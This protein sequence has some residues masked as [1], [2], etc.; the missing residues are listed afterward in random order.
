MPNSDSGASPD[1]RHRSSGRHPKGSTGESALADARGEFIDE[2]DGNYAS[3]LEYI[4]TQF[5]EWCTERQQVHTLGEVT[6]LTMRH[7]AQYLNRRVKANRADSSEG[8]SASSARTYYNYVSAFL[9]WA[10][11]TEKLPEN[12]AEKER[13]K[14]PLPEGTTSS[15]DQQ[16]WSPEQ[17]RALVEYVDEQARDAIDEN[18]MD[19][20]EEVRNRALITVL[21][22][23]GVRGSEVLADSRHDR[24]NGLRWRDVDLEETV[25]QVFGKGSQ[26]ME[27]VG[28]TGQTVEPLR[29]LRQ[30]LDPPSESWPVFPSKHPPSLYDRIDASPYD[31]PESDP[32]GYVLEKGI[33]PPSMSVSGARTL[34]KRLSKAA[35]V[36]GLDVE[37]GEYLT[38][39]GARRGVGET[40]FKEV[41]PQRAQRTLRHEDPKTT[42]KMYSHIEASELGEENTGVFDGE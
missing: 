39:H 18:G 30:V 25:M 28:L 1:E 32:W 3:N 12:P 13:A 22:Y 10:V 19:A 16:F 14:K 42:S 35:V 37:N 34:L 21:A 11:E 33:E 20:F 5:E 41:S 8:V 36:P 4:L 15:A 17:R 7:Y 6:T 26:D 27:D 31:R 40:L 23:T 29:R 2:K 38:L 9:T 24:R